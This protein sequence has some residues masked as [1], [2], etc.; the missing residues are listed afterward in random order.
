MAETTAQ[1]TTVRYS[2]VNHLALVTNDMD[3]TVRFYRDV[4][5]MDLIA[6]TGSDPDGYPYRHYFFSLGPGSTIAFFE[7][8]EVE[9][10]PRKDSGV[11]AS[12]RQFDHVAIAVESDED[13][14]RLRQRVESH[15]YAISELIDHGLVRSYY[16]EDPHGISLEFAVWGHDLDKEPFFEDRDPVPAARDQM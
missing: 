7:W 4:L 8:P 3:K 9:L 15:G 10:P 11:P 12:G 5:G 1:D 6:T 2:G 16:L 13:L 14:E